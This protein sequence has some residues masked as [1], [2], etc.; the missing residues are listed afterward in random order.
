M[1]RRC[2]SSIAK[3]NLVD[4]NEVISMIFIAISRKATRAVSDCWRLVFFV[5][6][7]FFER[8]VL[9]IWT[10]QNLLR[11]EYTQCQV[12]MWIRSSIMHVLHFFTLIKVRLAI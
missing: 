7:N 12:E 8:S 6:F 5:D 3:R 1:D 9:K 10:F 11:L 4:L 2:R